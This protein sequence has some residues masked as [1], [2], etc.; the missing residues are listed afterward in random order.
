MAIRRF[1]SLAAAFVNLAAAPSIMEALG[2][3][4]AR[5]GHW[6]IVPAFSAGATPFSATKIVAHAL[7][8][9]E[10]LPLVPTATGTA[11]TK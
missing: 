7:L 4:A 3:N 9:K 5:R 8:A 2:E 11:V 1:L 6:R 10:R